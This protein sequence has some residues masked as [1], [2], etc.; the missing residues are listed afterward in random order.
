METIN[1]Y[2]SKDH[3]ILDALF[4]EYRQLKRTDCAR[5]KEAFKKFLFGLQ[6]HIVWEEDILFPAFEE[7]TGVCEEG[8]TAV[9]R[10]EHRQIGAA[11]DELHEFVRRQDPD[12]DAV[13]ERLLAVLRPHNDKEEQVL[14]PAIDDFLNEEERTAIFRAMDEVP[15]ER[16]ATCCGGV[17]LAAAGGVLGHE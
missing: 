9:M 17:E 16:Y 4:Q 6:R 3:D 14:Y 13:E 2:F 12:S 10:H 7:K 5:A 15:E 11:L 1:E 8:P